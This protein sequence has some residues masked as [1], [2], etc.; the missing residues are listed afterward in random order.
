MKRLLAVLALATCLV[1]CGCEKPSAKFHPGDRVVVKAHPE[2]KG[3]VLL[4]ASPFI[5]DLYYLRVAGPPDSRTSTWIVSS[6]DKVS[7][8]WH[9]EGPY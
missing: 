4:R 8:H 7:K 9:L 6:S 3:G 2:T 1:V 5:D